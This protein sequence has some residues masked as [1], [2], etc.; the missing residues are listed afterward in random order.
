MDLGG[1]PSVAISVAPNGGR[2]TKQEHP[3]VPITVPE[4]ARTAAGCAAAGAAMIH[5]H[6]R[7]RA[8]RH[9]LDPDAY[10]DAI[11]AIRREAG[12]DIVVQITSESLGL[13]QP[14]EQAAV[15]RAAHPEAVSMA[16]REFLPNSN[17]EAAFAELLEW[18]SRSQIFPQFI[19]YEPGEARY[20]DNLCR[21]GVV[22]W[23]SPPV[24][25]V[26]GRYTSGQLS[27]PPDLLP[28]ITGDMPRFAHWSVCAFGYHE[29][30]CVTTAALLGGH[31]R[32]GF[33]NNRF[34]PSGQQA[35]KNEDLVTAVTTP[36]IELGRR[37]QTSSEWRAAMSALLRD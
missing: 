19:L 3:A 6:V 12:D 26:L 14:D 9:I 23:R 18:M 16:V 25:Y 22:P 21:R 35:A 2:I 4:L 32:V 7:D 1:S 15:I 27:Y 20:L 11:A 8:G 31:V 37:L 29:A 36:L 24:L 33:E 28:F 13:Y 17:R 34:L 5:I 10:R 30:A